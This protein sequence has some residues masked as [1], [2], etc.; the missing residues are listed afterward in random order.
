MFWR[1]LF[2]GGSSPEPAAAA[3]APA[4]PAAEAWAGS[5]GEGEGGVEQTGAPAP[6]GVETELKR[7]NTIT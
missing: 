2:S 1:A 7:S 3:A 5:V 6:S 4:T